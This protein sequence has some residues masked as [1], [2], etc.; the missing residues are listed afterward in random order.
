MQISGI[1]KYTDFICV[2][3]RNDIFVFVKYSLFISLKCSHINSS[4][5]SESVHNKH[6]FHLWNLLF[7]KYSSFAVFNYG[8]SFNTVF[9]LN[10]KKVSLDNLCHLFSAAK[11][12]FILFNLPDTFIIF[13]LK[14]KNFKTNQLVQ[15]HFQYC[16]CLSFR[17]IKTCSLLF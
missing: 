7:L 2:H 14:I 3:Y 5:I 8:S 11:Y 6:N 4:C 16:S 13:F 12:L 1:S 9:L 10:I 17:E 15:T